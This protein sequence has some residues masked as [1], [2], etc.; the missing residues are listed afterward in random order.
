[1]KKSVEFISDKYE[2]ILIELAEIKKAESLCRQE[3]ESIKK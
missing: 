3:N 1:L 2:N